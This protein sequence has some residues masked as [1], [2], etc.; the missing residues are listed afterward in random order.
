LTRCQ[1]RGGTHREAAKPAASPPVDAAKKR[2][3]RSDAQRSMTD[4]EHSAWRRDRR[5][6]GVAASVASALKVTE[7]VAP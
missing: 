4:A 5:Q 7:E 2:F 3:F 6:G 1:D